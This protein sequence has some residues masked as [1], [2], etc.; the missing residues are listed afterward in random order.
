MPEITDEEIEN[1]LKG[2]AVDTSPGPDKVIIGSIKSHKKII[3]I[4][5]LIGTIMLQKCFVPKSFQQART[6]LNKKEIQLHWGIGDQYA[7]IY[8]CSVLR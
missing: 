1:S 3:T 4:H 6:V 8:I 7:N 2:V 5:A